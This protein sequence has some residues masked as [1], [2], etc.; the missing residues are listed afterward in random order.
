MKAA[1]ERERE[2]EQQKTI[3]CWR[4]MLYHQTTLTEN[5]FFSFFFYEN[6]IRLKAQNSKLNQVN[7]FLKVA[8]KNFDKKRA[9]DK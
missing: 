3:D 5:A 7:R 4:W 1:G 9:N 6:F 8:K 2:R